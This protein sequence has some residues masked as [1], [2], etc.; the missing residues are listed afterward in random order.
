MLGFNPTNVT[1]IGALLAGIGSFMGG[2]AAI[3]YARKK[4]KQDALKD[5]P[6]PRND[7]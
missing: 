4:A 7:G 1:A 3:Y 6:I 5:P 2:F